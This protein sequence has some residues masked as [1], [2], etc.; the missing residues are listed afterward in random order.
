MLQTVRQGLTILANRVRNVLARGTLVKITNGETQGKSTAKAQITV[1]NGEVIDGI[2]FPQQFGFISRPI[3]GAAAI[4]LFFGG[5]RDHGTVNTIYDKRFA[6]ND[7][8]EG[9]VV[10]Y[11]IITGTKIHLKK[12]GEILVKSDKEIK[13]ECPNT[14]TSITLQ[15]DGRIVMKSNV[16]VVV[17]TP[18]VTLTGD[19]NVEGDIK[20][21]INVN[22]HNVRNMREIYNDHKHGGVSP[23]GAETFEPDTDM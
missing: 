18:T 17:D 8:E 1:M 9:E 23:G 14:N 5:N 10:L 6:P 15:E 22:T 16:E 13:L 2:E 4:A 3:K 20:D 11:N 21:K 7:L 19:L 12:E